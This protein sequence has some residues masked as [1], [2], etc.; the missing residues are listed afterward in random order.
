MNAPTSKTLNTTR[1]SALA[2]GL[3]WLMLML[4]VAVYACIELSD[5]FPKGSDTRAAFKSWHYML[6]L[7]VFVLVWIRAAIH[8]GGHA[9]LIEPAPP[10]WQARLAQFVQIALYVLMVSLPLVGWLLLSAK[11]QPVV[12]FGWPL[13][14]LMAE[15]K[16]A[17]SWIKEVHEAGA[18]A[19]YFLVGVHALA[20]LY[21]H[22]FLHDNTLSRIL[23]RSK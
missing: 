7:S 18:N 16:D 8:L 9:P 22:Y 14:A 21:H 10:V 23:P 6:G 11:G 13:P 15:N 3:H 2:I 4:L 17:A 5:S 20:A 1:Y 19:G 12:F